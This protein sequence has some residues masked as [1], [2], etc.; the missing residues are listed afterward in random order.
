MFTLLALVLGTLV[1]EDLTA[2]TAGLLVRDGELDFAAAAAACGAGIYLGDLGLWLAG[3]LLGSRVLQGPRVRALLPAGGS[4]RFAAWF[5]RRAALTI[6]GSRFTPGTRL[7]LYLAAG[8]CRS[9][10]SR[11]AWWSAVAVAI[12]TPSLVA[13]SAAFGH[14][15]A[16]VLSEWF[17]TGRLL[18]L[19][20]A[21]IGLLGWRLALVASSHR[22][23]QR[24]AARVARI[25]RWEFWPMWLFYAPVA[26]WT[27]WLAL[28][29]GGYRTITSANP[30]MPDGGVVGES[31]FDILARLPSGAA[32]PSAAI[33]PAALDTRCDRLGAIIRAAG[34]QLPI[35]L[36]PDV[37]QRGTGVRIV[38]TEQEAAEYLRRMT[39]RVLVQ[40]YHP[41]PFEAG[42][43]YYRMPD[44]DRGRILCITDKHFPIV[45]GDG[46]TTLEDLV[47]AHPRY[48]MQAQTFLARLGDRRH[49]VPGR[50]ERVRLGLAGNH[51]QGTMFTDGRALITP[52]LESRID[53]IARTYPGF[54]IGRFDIRY[55]DR[56][57]F[58]AGRDLAIVELN[59]ATAECTNIYDPAGTLL[60][61]YR[62]LFLQWKLVF[63]IGAA[64]RRRGCPSSSTARL[65]RLLGAHL[66]MPE[67]FAVSD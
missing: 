11:F 30:G 35:V 62:Q 32:I 39:T 15:S 7:P 27:A 57:A 36:K 20:S 53:A 1:S 38:R 23:R 66:S 43:F 59:G 22:G 54:F 64:N 65:I 49:D 6:L 10:F 13:V 52:A 18:T 12:W 8:A 50:E 33:E 40:P 16:A 24:M 56:E 14:H 42:V 63:A 19:T 55:A 61:A 21:L 37:G 31:K 28:R 29:Y 45:V 46:A 34:W 58:M 26:A 51:A 67:E 2:I 25:W 4:V 41:G 48:R 47:W 5:D 44:W 9:S 3:R 17:V 60:A